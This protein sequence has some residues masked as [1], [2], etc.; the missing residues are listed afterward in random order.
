MGVAVEQACC[1]KPED[2][3]GGGGA[4]K[5]RRGCRRGRD[6]VKLAAGSR[7]VDGSEDSGGEFVVWCGG[8]AV[9]L[10]RQKRS[11]NSQRT[12]EVGHPQPRWVTCPQFSLMTSLTG[13]PH[14]A[15]D[16]SRATHRCSRAHGRCSL[17]A[18]ILL[19]SVQ[20]MF[21]RAVVMAVR[22]IPLCSVAKGRSS[23]TNLH[24]SAAFQN[25]P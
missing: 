21:R 7:W 13:Q 22:A 20:V 11:F 25:I 23:T 2:L 18:K 9:V 12:F 15:C 17:G 19:S 16:A 5:T 3:V 10:R 24:S 4:W 1:P 6:G 8:G 14:N